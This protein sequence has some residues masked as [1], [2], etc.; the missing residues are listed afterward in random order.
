MQW[1]IRA[2]EELAATSAKELALLKQE[3]KDV[4]NDRHRQKVAKVQAV[5]ETRDVRRLLQSG[6]KELRGELSKQRQTAADE[7]AGRSLAC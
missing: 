7:V 4:T 6:M 3:L 1:Q 2:T 5:R